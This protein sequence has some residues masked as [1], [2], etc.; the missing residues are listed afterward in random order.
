MGDKRGGRRMT[1]AQRIR[2][3][4]HR[5]LSER[6]VYSIVVPNG[7]RVDTLFITSDGYATTDKSEAVK[8]ELG[9]LQQPAKEAP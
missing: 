5:E 4:S 6:N 8:H 2:G 1:N 7:Y 9:W 3:M